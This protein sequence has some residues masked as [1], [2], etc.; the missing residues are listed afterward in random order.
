MGSRNVL[1][2]TCPWRSVGA[3][4][5]VL[6]IGLHAQTACSEDKPTGAL[7]CVVRLDGK[8]P[9]ARVVKLDAEM[10]ETMG[11]AEYQEETFLLGKDQGLANCVILLRAKDPQQRAEPRPLKPATFAKVGLRFQPRVL[12][13]TPGTNVSL[14]NE[15][16][17]CRGF[18][19]LS[20]RNDDHR[21]AHMVFEGQQERVSFKKP[22]VCEIGCPLRPYARGFIVV[23]DT[24]YFAM[25][26]ADG[27]ATVEKIPPG[28][29]EVSLWH[30][31]LDGKQA[32]KPHTT[33]VV[34]TDDTTQ[35]KLTL[36]APKPLAP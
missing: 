19:V 10:R 27:Q 13:V 15:K 25:T 17:P 8:A 11:V 9:E 4:A 6:I 32:R 35:L 12:V 21:F 36:P 22:D 33:V 5:L 14:T 1:Q 7:R 34:R 18:K 23:A 20:C 16:S 29:Y 3:L 28:E 31:S 26:D 30:E 24:P 2:A